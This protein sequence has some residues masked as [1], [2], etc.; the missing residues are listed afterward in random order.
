M[1]R[2]DTALAYLSRVLAVAVRAL[3]SDD[4]GDLTR[5]GIED[6][7]TSELDQALS[8][9]LAVVVADPTPAALDEVDA[10]LAGALTPVVTRMLEQAAL[11]GV[12]QAQMEL[13]GLSVDWGV[14]NRDALVW[15]RDYAGE[16]VRGLNAT[17]RDALRREIA[18]WI[19]S[20]EPLDVLARRLEP[21]F[22]ELRGRVIAETEV[23][24]AFAEGQYQA[25]QRAG[26]AR[27]T[28]HTANDERVC[29][30]CQPRDGVTYPMD[31]ERP[32]AHVRCRCW[33]TAAT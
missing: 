19:E 9:G 14:V 8:V 1:Q 22:G 32:P 29:H 17:T 30:V 18:A 16:L 13:G 5:R 23:T 28:W 33:M 24:R 27:W 3:P 21:M 4:G 20:G 26:V 11:S 10:A 7:F 12:A 31:A 2:L 15:A 25:F 6:T